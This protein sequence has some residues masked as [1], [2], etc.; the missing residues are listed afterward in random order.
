LKTET[1]FPGATRRVMLG[2]PTLQT[3]NRR[4]C[5]PIAMPLS[6]EPMVG[7][8][9][10][11][12]EAYTAVSQHFSHVDPEIEQLVDLTLHFSNDKPKGEL[13]AA[14]DAKVP[15]AELRKF[16]VLRV[17][18]PESPDV[19][20]RFKA[21][22]PFSREFWRWIGEMAGKEVYMA[23][24]SSLGKGVA[25]M[26]ANGKLIDEPPTEAETEA[27]SGDTKPEE[28]ET[29]GPQPGSPEYE[30]QVAAS[31][32][33]DKAVTKTRFERVESPHRAKG[34]GKSGPAEL[35]AFHAK[36]TAAPRK[37]G[38]GLTTVN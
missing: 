33:A 25:V 13:F 18:E 15:G 31:L 30:K 28:A 10:W 38:R 20:L 11:V 36:Q 27:L 8:P 23:F 19:E 16:E 6:D 17:G 34:N 21:Y 35:K 12:G 2:S 14:P 37:N 5:I 22:T 9:D 26:P 7:M 1:F 29:A 4:I 24:P 32:G 3:S